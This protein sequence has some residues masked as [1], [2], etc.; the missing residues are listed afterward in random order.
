MIRS[1][2]NEAL[3]GM[4]LKGVNILKSINPSTRFLALPPAIL[5][6]TMG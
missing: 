6:K 4:D 3:D 5:L 2:W 1:T